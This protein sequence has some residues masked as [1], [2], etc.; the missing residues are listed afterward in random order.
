MCFMTNDIAPMKLFGII[1]TDLFMV[2]M[3]F[4]RWQTSV[5]YKHDIYN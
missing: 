5:R 1:A 2:Y 4:W 3:A